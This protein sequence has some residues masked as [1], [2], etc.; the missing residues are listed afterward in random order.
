MWS[1]CRQYVGLLCGAV[2]RDL[3]VV[4]TSDGPGQL[5]L[6]KPLASV[7]HLNGWHTVKNIRKRMK[8]KIIT[9]LSDSNYTI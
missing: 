2:C 9:F 4:Y 3:L 7:A 6:H 5:T 1:A 8:K